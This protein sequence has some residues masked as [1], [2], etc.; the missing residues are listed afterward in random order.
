M[1]I[2]RRCN[3]LHRE[4][5]TTEKLKPNNPFHIKRFSKYISWLLDY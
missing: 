4:N 1:M 5:E 2:V 3:S